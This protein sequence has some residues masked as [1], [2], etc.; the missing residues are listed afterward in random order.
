MLIIKV[1]LLYMIRSWC[2]SVL[3]Y[4]LKISW[5]D[6]VF[7]IGL[8]VSVLSMLRAIVLKLASTE[9]ISVPLR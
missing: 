4:N 5:V 6:K 8:W 1:C 9:G 2:K 3:K 7:E